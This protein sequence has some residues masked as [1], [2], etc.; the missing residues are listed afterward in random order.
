MWNSFV[1][2]KGGSRG[3]GGVVE[4]KGIVELGLREKKVVVELRV[5]KEVLEGIDYLERMR[6]GRWLRT[7]R[8]V[9]VELVG[10]MCGVSGRVRRFWVWK[11]LWV[12]GKGSLNELKKG[13]WCRL[14]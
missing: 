13:W 10:V 3:A 4:L 8:V 11:S 9:G 2:F 1:G 5:V 7:E 12:R 6:V 14:G